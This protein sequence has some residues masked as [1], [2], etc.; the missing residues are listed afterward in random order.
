MLCVDLTAL[1]NL[2]GLLH[3]G[4]TLAVLAFLVSALDACVNDCGGHRVH[5]IGTMYLAVF[6]LPTEGADQLSVLNRAY[7]Y[8]DTNGHNN[9]TNNVDLQTSVKS[10]CTDVPTAQTLSEVDESKDHGVERS[11]APCELAVSPTERSAL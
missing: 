9:S 4:D 7:L 3:A 10:D 2:S 1:K 8:Q 5:V 11:A 6:G